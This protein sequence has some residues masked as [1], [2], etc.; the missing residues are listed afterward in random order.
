VRR[1]ELVDVQSHWIDE[2][3]ARSG[4]REARLGFNAQPEIIA[5]PL[6]Y[7]AQGGCGD[8]GTFINLKLNRS[9]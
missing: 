2:I 5:V 3:R 7:S 1:L 9:D 4:P 8:R 6:K